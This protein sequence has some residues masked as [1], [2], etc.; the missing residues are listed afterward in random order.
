MTARLELGR[1]ASRES[2]TVRADRLR[3]HAVIVGMTGSG[4]TGLGLVLLEELVA[5]GVPIIAVDPKGDLGNLGLLFP[6]FRPEDFAPWCGQQDPGKVA[7]KWQGGLLTAGMTADRVTTVRERLAMTVYTPG[8]S[9]GVPIDLFGLLSAPPAEVVA[10][11]EARTA[12]VSAA[13]SGLLGLAGRKADP[14]KDPAHVTLS[15]IIE[16]AWQAGASLDLSGLILQLVDPPFDKVGVFPV[17]RF[18]APDDRM[19]LAMAFNAI[20]A[21][22]NFRAWRRGASVDID[23]FLA[24]GDRTPVSVFNIAHLDDRQRQFFVSLLL[25]KLLAWSRRQPGTE[26]LRAVLFFDEVAGYLP[27]YPRNPPCK[28]P[29]LT[30]M[31]QARSVGL[32]VILSTQNPVDLDY[33][34]LSNAGLWC[35]GRLS[36][37]QDRERLLKGIDGRDLDG[38]VADLGKRE[39]LLHEIGRG[40]PTTFSTRHAMCYLR[41]PLTSVEVG[42]LNAWLG[43]QAVEDGPEEPSDPSRARGTGAWVAEDDEPDRDLLPAAP[44]VPG[45]SQHFLDPRVAF[46]ARLEGAF[47]RDVGP[48]RGDDITVYRPALYAVLRLRFDEKRDGFVLDHHEVRVWFPLESTR[49]GRPQ[50]VEIRDTDLVLPPKDRARFHPLP[51]W[52]DEAGE[53]KRLRREVIDEVYRTETRGRFANGALGLYGRAEETRRAFDA[54]CRA[55]VEARIDAAI[56]KHKERFET[57]AARLD[58]KLATKRA[59]LVER[60]GVS[61]S[62]QLE[63]AVNVGATILSFFG[64]RKKSL[65]SVVSRRRQ[66]TQA[67]A[68]VNRL[69]GEIARLEEDAEELEA[70][71]RSKIQA[72]QHDQEALLAETEERRVRLEKNDIDLSVFGVLWVPSHRRL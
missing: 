55:E 69:Q 17:D 23:R 3:T 29:L 44:T 34:A 8:S 18:F 46:S 15:F 2:L 59:E 39:F 45:L 57:K 5:A 60:Q 48:A 20:F 21:S 49:P 40:E 56:E 65:T 38:T 31:K 63:E 61:R 6:Q 24:D 41:G 66:T 16:R 70:D 7:R 64:G 4:K 19:E 50:A 12:V 62:R 42:K 9:A 54:R 36:T 37:V 32:G 13:V 1:N 51:T 53:V 71:L 27:P 28:D 35:I 22:P 58:D 52:M 68:R 26:D 43:V 33:K 25:S 10:D 30:L 14:V 11:D 67:A 72:I 47:E